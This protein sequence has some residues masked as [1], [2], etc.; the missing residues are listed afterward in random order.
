MKQI[1]FGRTGLSVSPLGLG[2]GPIGDPALS[3][4]HAGTLL[5]RA[6]DRG[7]TLIDTAPSYGESEARIGRH[8][9]W[10]RGDFVLSTKL[11]YGVPGVAD[12]TPDCID[13]G[14]DRALARMGTDRI[15]IAHLHSCPL[16]TLQRSGVVEALGRAV[17]D[18]RVG[19]AAYSG[20][21]DALAWAVRAGAFG[22]V[23]FSL[24]IVDR[25][26]LAL[27]DEMRS[28]GLGLIVKRGLANAV[29]RFAQPPERPD[30]A[31]YWRRFTALGLDRPAD[32]ADRAL[33]F[34]LDAAPDATVLV[35]TT[36]IDHLEHD[37]KVAA[38]HVPGGATGFPA[39]AY[40]AVGGDWPSLI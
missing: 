21:N 32:I 8:L 27:L 39:Q 5:N 38:A 2:A 18:G 13:K 28:R 11:G 26:A 35:G 14:V 24:N 25:K 10:R 1:P 9:S 33:A 40:A 3:E 16:E 4:D 31:E 7:V 29:W 6:V 23:Q 17:H 37:A 22:G 34:C 19:V 15:D 20:D 12:W 30:L 36:R